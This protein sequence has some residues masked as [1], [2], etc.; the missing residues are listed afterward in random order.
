M[1][2]K[3]PFNVNP[4]LS[5]YRKRDPIYIINKLNNNGLTLTNKG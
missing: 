2:E 3:Q 5:I 4:N 1:R